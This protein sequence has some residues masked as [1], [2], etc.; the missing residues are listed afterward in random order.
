MIK[1]YQRLYNMKPSPEIAKLRT[2]RP[3]G[4]MTRNGSMTSLYSRRES[5]PHSIRSNVSSRPQT[6]ISSGTF[7]HKRTQDFQGRT[8]PTSSIRKFLF[9][10]DSFDPIFNQCN[11]P[12]KQSGTKKYTSK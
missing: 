8:E 6:A 10:Q 4:S 11:F 2:K 12:G 3:A 9:K 5:R 1:H 7:N